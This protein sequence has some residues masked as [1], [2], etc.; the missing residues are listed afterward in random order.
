MRK[1]L[2]LL[3]VSLSILLIASGAMAASYT[4]IDNG[5][6]GVRLQVR[7]L[8][9]T[10]SLQNLQIGFLDQ[11]SVF[12]GAAAK[13]GY[14]PVSVIPAGGNVVSFALQEGSNITPL[15]AGTLHP[16]KWLLTFSLPSTSPYGPATVNIRVQNGDS[17]AGPVEVHTPEPASLFLLAGTM[18]VGLGFLR[19]R[20]KKSSV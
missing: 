19:K 9:A 3:A 17:M 5:S 4:M 8:N 2:T 7:I 6:D 16:D 15:G 13:S 11:A 1:L 20:Q 18:I 12:Y 14:T 10:S